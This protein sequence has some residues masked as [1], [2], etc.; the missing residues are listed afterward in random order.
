MNSPTLVCRCFLPNP[1][2]IYPYANLSDI[3]VCFLEEVKSCRQSCSSKIPNRF[4]ESCSLLLE[5]TGHSGLTGLSRLLMQ[6]TK[7][8]TALTI[9]FFHAA[10]N[11]WPGKFRKLLKLP[12]L[13]SFLSAFLP[14]DLKKTSRELCRTHLLLSKIA[15]VRQ[16]LISPGSGA[17]G[18][19]SSLQPVM[20]HGIYRS[21]L[22]Q[23]SLTHKISSSSWFLKGPGWELR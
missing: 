15:T 8:K 1:I 20:W 12:V 5:R 2:H 16:T 9:S 23:K 18:N 6:W 4:Q 19:C 13:P 14:S 21:S 17:S 11:P 3:W 22:N 7:W 10:G